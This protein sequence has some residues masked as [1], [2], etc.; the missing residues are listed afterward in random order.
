[1][2]ETAAAVSADG[3]N[4]RPERINCALRPDAQGFDEIRIVTI[5]RFKESELSGDEWRISAR[6]E[7]MRNGVIVHTSGARDVETAS[8]MLYG[9]LMRTFDDAKG[10][11]AGDGIHCDQE[12]CSAM[13]TRQYQKVKHFEHGYE[14]Q[15]F[16]K[17]FRHLCGRHSTR[18]NCS[19]D[20]CDANYVEVNGFIP[21]VT[22]YQK[23]RE[24]QYFD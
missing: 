3:C 6:I 2:S 7:F 18:G 13:A 8:G 20:D 12:G 16:S 11:F 5:P 14:R 21:K 4:E 10:W 24:S 15:S 17:E 22:E 1:M 19:M 23:A 9:E